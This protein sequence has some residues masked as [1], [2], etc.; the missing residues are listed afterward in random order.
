MSLSY[1][2]APLLLRS[3]APPLP[4]SSAPP[5]PRPSAE[6]PNWTAVLTIPNIKVHLYG[7][8]EARDGRKM[9]H[10]TALADSVEEAEKVVRE[11]REL[12]RD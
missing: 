10:L 5:L 11:A 1:P 3:S 7:K 8:R 9:G 12:L 6:V 2:S 4:R